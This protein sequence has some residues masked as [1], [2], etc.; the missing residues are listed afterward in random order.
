MDRHNAYLAW[1]TLITALGPAPLLAFRFNEIQHLPPGAD[2]GLAYVELYN[3]LGT[4]IDLTRWR[5]EGAITYRFPDDTRVPGRGYV[6]VA[7]APQ[8]L[9]ARHPGIRVFGPFEGDLSAGGDLILRNFANAIAD[10]IT[11]DVHPP[12]PPGTAGSG[13]TLSKVD[14]ERLSRSPENWTLSDRIGGTPGARNVAAGAAP[15]F[16]GGPLVINEL[17]RDGKGGFAL[18]L[19]N[20]GSA[21][22]DLGSFR[23]R[24]ASDSGMAAGAGAIAPGARAMLTDPLFASIP[25]DGTFALLIDLR[26]AEPVSADG[27]WIAPDGPDSWGRFPDGGA[28]RYALDAPSP[29]AANAATLH[30]EIAI[31]EIMYH[32]YSEDRDLQYV[33]LVNRSDHAVDLSYW[34]FLEG[35]RFE[36]PSNTWIPAGGYLVVAR[37][38]DLIRRLYGVEAIG[39]F[40]GQLSFDGETI[41]LADDRGNIADRVRYGED[42][43]WPDEADGWGSSLE[44]IHPDRDNALA[45][46]WA[47]SDEAP[48]AQWKTYR[49][50]GTKPG[51]G[52][53]IWPLLW[54]E[55]IFGS[56]TP[57]EFLID[58]LSIR[59]QG[60]EL[61][62]NGNFEAP[63]SGWRVLG[64]HN[65][66]K[67]VQ[68]PDD[69]A[70]HVL[71][72]V[73]Q[74][75]QDDGFNHLE[76]T[77]NL[78]DNVLHEISFRARWVSGS[79]KINT[80]FYYNL[81]PETHRL[82]VPIPNGT[83]GKPNSSL[84][85]VPGPDIDLVRHEPVFPKA[86][87]TVTVRARI[88]AARGL[89]GATLRYDVDGTAGSPLAMR[90]DG[91]GGDATAGDGVFAATIPA[92]KN[93]AVVRFSIE[94]I[95][96]AAGK[97]LFPPDG[98]WGRA[99]YLVAT[100]P[101]AATIHQLAIILPKADAT[102]MLNPP[103]VMSN[104]KFRTTVVYDGAPIYDVPVRLTASARGR[105]AADRVSFKIYLGGERALRGSLPSLVVDRALKRGQVLTNHLIRR[106]GGLPCPDEEIIDFVFSNASY[107]GRS[108]LTG[109]YEGGFAEAQ[110]PGDEGTFFKLQNLLYLF[111]ETYT[112]RPDGPKKPT[113]NTV[114]GYDIKD[115]GTDPDEYR[116]LA[117]IY[118]RRKEDDYQ[119]LMAAYRA[120]SASGTDAL[121]A[122]VAE[123]YDVDSWLRALAY[124]GV[125]ADR[126]TYLVGGNQ[127]N[128]MFY[129]SG[130]DRHI[131]YLPYD[132]DFSFGE[133]GSTGSWNS[134]LLSSPGQNFGRVV[135]LPENNRRFLAHARRAVE[136]VFRDAYM[137]PWIDYYCGLLQSSPAEFKNWMRQRR[138]Y[139]QGIL[140]AG[141]ED[142][143]TS[144]D[145]DR[146]G[147]GKWTMR[148][149]VSADVQ[150]IRVA[151]ATAGITWPNA[152]SW[153]FRGGPQHLGR[154]LLVEFLD[155]D[156][157]VH[158]ALTVHP[159]Q[160]VR[161]DVNGDGF[162]TLADPISGLNHLFAGASI[163]CEAGFDANASGTTDLADAIRILMLLFGGQ[164]DLPP[165]YPT[166]GI[167]DN[168]A[169][170]GCQSWCR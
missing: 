108:I 116:L 25:L 33:E 46:S 124:R 59:A 7:R 86:T 66:S 22:L 51:S 64:N 70:N 84:I 63:L 9:L 91:T 74:G 60:R 96:E 113:P 95:D 87:Q 100:P 126:D 3:D 14:P 82:E 72:V 42:H 150:S 77:L 110:W 35:L 122:Q 159:I 93:A 44:L 141:G 58:D 48:R 144:I 83:P 109:S 107:S 129:V 169:G 134:P 166:C 114:V 139:L 76:I 90:D 127:H 133:Y 69:P 53:T 157:E 168:K 88:R 99:T 118:N 34:F 97:T 11:F 151:G 45:A 50:Q 130:K 71:H 136:E 55:F 162:I 154:P 111:T 19:Y 85:A 73:A 28:D 37:N 18:E 38:A 6:A 81:L 156:Q 147:G 79:D 89:A 103:D 138:T 104:E 143:I 43:P 165:P 31:N 29:G 78:P 26:E 36:F 152:S 115:Y 140:G 112:G 8:A 161:G 123:T 15:S 47:P 80:R 160:Y 149:T 101:A 52:R 32:P 146:D 16:G 41:V 54:K 131:W 145:L 4:D 17:L 125:A 142:K 164:S 128:G 10:R 98:T 120:L 67:I 30:D 105:T 106:A 132:V 137:D 49:Y 2:P 40:D 148:G 61:L 68:D 153:I 62:S 170:L 27:I 56:L 94:A 39:D 21:P 1:L 75:P 23:I 167:E 92:A 121:R 163:T 65:R 12:W 20:R 155:A 135:N 57:G 102:R 158:T 5:I 117:T 13:F 119:G 24:V